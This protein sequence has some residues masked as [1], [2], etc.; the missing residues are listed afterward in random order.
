MITIKLINMNFLDSGYQNVIDFIDRADRLK[1]FNSKESKNF[2]LNIKTDAIR[3][4]ITLPCDVDDLRKYDY[5][6]FVEE[7]KPFF[8]FIIEKEHISNKASKIHIELDVWTTY[9]HDVWFLDTF[10]DRCHVPRW[11]NNGNP[12]RNT[13]DEGLEYGELIEVGTT[14][15]LYDMK[16]SIVV[17]SSVPIGLLKGGIKPTPIPP[18]PS[19]DPDTPSKGTI[20]AK[21]FRHIKGEEGFAPNPYT[22]QGESWRTSGYGCTERWQQELFNDLKPFPTPEEKASIVLL[23][24]LKEEFIPQII[25]SLKKNNLKPNDFKVQQFDVLCSLTM[26]SGIGNLTGSSLWKKIVTNPHDTTIPEAIKKYAVNY[27]GLVLRRQRESDMWRAGLYNY[28]SISIINSKG[29]SSGTNVSGDGYIPPELG[30]ISGILPLPGFPKITNQ[31]GTMICPTSG[32]VTATFP[33]YPGG[34]NHNGFDIASRPRGSDA[35]TYACKEGTVT[36]AGEYTGGGMESY[37]KVIYIEHG[38]GIVTRYAHHKSIVV[39]VGQKV[40][41]GQHIGWQGETGNVTGRHLHFELHVDGKRV[42]PIT[43]LSLGDTIKNF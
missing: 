15:K 35:K 23:R 28:K 30:S 41:A 16:K 14:E 22:L 36:K 11:D 1:Y 13:L 39:N 10:V 34:A 19:P 33:T 31:V 4:E 20:S 8:Y 6:Y 42:N 7:N 29:N 32:E 24:T 27:P 21:G 2:D 38:N 12:T 18:S 26:N 43:N 37:G 40:S 17:A 9:Q 25:S 5:M 3:T